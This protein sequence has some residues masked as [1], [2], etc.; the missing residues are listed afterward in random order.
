[1]QQLLPILTY[2]CELYPTPSEQQRRL[3]NQMYRWTLGVYKGSGAD[4]VQ[5]FVG[6]SDL[7]VV[8]AN[9]RIRWAASVYWRHEPELREKA[10]PILREVL[11]DDTEMRWM[12]GVWIGG[13]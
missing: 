5:D 6:V 3:A 7:G 8:M 4:K 1:V 9:K 11:E 2:G 10:E 12:Q 13:S